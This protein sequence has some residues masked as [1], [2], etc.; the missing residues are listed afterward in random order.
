MRA[1]IKTAQITI[2]REEAIKLLAE[3]NDILQ[4]LENIKSSGKELNARPDKFFQLHYVV[5][6]I[7]K[8]ESF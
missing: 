2:S 1:K 7:A 5:S 4:D 6:S 3:M 8:W